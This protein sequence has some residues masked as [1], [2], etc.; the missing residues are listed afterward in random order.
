M[1]ALFRRPALQEYAD[2]VRYPC[3]IVEQKWIREGLHHFAIRTKDQQIAQTLFCE[4]SLSNCDQLTISGPRWI[5]IIQ[6]NRFT[7]DDSVAASAVVIGD[8]KPRPGHAQD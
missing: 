8:N 2:R 4:R 3:D 1:E 7:L 6:S 5:A